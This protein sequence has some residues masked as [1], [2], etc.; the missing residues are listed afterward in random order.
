MI[1]V[2]GRRIRDL[3]NTDSTRVEP[4]DY[5]STVT[6]SVLA[7]GQD[8]EFLLSARRASVT[9]GQPVDVHIEVGSQVVHRGP[10]VFQGHDLTYGPD[11]GIST[12]TLRGVRVAARVADPDPGA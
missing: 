6:F 4:N 11:G 9:M 12:Y 2:A 7:G 10:H 3:V 8:D 5:G 1:A